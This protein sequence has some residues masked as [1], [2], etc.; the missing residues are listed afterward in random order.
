MRDRDLP[1]VGVTGFEAGTGLAVDDGD[2]VAGLLQEPGGGDAGDTG[3]EDD[4]FHGAVSFLLVEAQ[5]V[6]RSTAWVRQE[7]KR[8]RA[9]LAPLPLSL[10]PER[11]R[12]RCVQ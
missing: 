4:N 10:V 11:F 3:A 9:P 12:R 2:V 7:K 1:A 8:E 5:R 6:R